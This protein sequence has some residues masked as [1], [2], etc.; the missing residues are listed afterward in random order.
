MDNQ[1]EKNLDLLANLHLVLGIFTILNLN[2]DTTNELF[3]N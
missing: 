2:K 3:I 1:D